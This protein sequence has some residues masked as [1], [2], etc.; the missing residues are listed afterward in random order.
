MET[1]FQNEPSKIFN[2]R[3]QLYTYCVYNTTWEHVW[4]TNILIIMHI[5]VTITEN[6][7]IILKPVSE[8]KVK[9]YDVT[10]CKL[11]LYKIDYLSNL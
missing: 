6:I 2:H 4:T 1:G 7:V 10:L 8:V 5:N 9:E 11:F 3:K